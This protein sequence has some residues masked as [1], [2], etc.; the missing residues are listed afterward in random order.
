MT[1]HPL[2]QDLSLIRDPR[3]G[4]EAMEYI[5]RTGSICEWR[6]GWVFKEGQHVQRKA[7]RLG[8]PSCVLGTDS[9]VIAGELDLQTS[10]TQIHRA[11]SL[12]AHS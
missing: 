2:T 4:P 1:L 10:V 5:L 11:L 6:A 7:Q 8:R 3:R 9:T 12:P